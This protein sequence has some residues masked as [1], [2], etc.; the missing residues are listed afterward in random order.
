MI[1]MTEDRTMSLHYPVKH[2]VP[3]WL[4]L[5]NLPILAPSSQGKLLTVGVIL[6]RYQHL[7]NVW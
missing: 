4:T 1:I 5:R 6:G 7:L 2:L 3:I